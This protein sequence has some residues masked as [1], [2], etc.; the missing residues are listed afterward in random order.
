MDPQRAELMQQAIQFLSD[1]Q[2]RSSTLVQR[3]QFLEARGLTNDEITRAI[4]TANQSAVNPGYNSYGSAGPATLP[5]QNPVH[6]PWD[7]RDY[8]IAAV[9]SGSVM[10][11][12]HAIAKKYLFPHLKPP[13][14]S[15]YEAD[16]EALA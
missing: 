1:P 2:T 3:I 7:W 8:F 6:V 14:L 4:V 12:A 16:K 9:V 15:A 10:L 5:G 11:G 13:T